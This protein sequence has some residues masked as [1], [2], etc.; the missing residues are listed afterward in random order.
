MSQRT[1]HFLL[2]VFG[3]W[4]LGALAIAIPISYEALPH[5][6]RLKRDGVRTEGVITRLE[7][8]NHRAVDYTYNVGGEVFSGI[9][10]SGFGNPDFDRLAV[11]QEVIVYYLSYDSRESCLGIPDELFQNDL[12]PIILS[13]ITFPLLA[14]GV[15]SY[16]FPHFRR[17][18]FA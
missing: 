9:G 12:Q 5:F 1:S 13:G 16:R 4:L 8:G 2:K 11:G 3:L 14:L 18:L 17:W 7:P 15:N 6:Y 10:R